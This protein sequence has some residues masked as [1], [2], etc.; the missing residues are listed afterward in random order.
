MESSL[1]DYARIES[2]IRFIETRA[3]E[4]PGLEAIAAYLGLSP[5]HLQRLFSRWAGVSPKKFLEFITVA[6]AKKLL[7]QSASVL[8]TALEVGLSGPSRLHDMFVHIEAVSPGEYK[9]MGQGLELRWGIFP[10]P[11]GPC[12]IAESPRGIC[13]LEFFE[14]PAIAESQAEET[15]AKRWSKAALVRDEE[16]AQALG[17]RIFASLPSRAGADPFRLLVKGSAFQIKVWKGLLSIPEGRLVSYGKFAEMIGQAGAARA[18][19]SAIGDNPIGYL[20]PCH[21][22]LRSSGEFGGYKWGL[23]RKK[24]LIAREASQALLVQPSPRKL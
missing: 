1:A 16:S 11:F 24:A 4:Q 18:V 6:G 7:D 14:S 10:S 20:I 23:E 13:A 3:K 22:V 21:R 15:L 19:G 8:D 2:A 9:S 5:F 12:L 17:E